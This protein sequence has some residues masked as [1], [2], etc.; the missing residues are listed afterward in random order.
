M[1][2]LLLL[3]L[4]NLY[5]VVALVPRVSAQNPP[6]Y[7]VTGA[8]TRALYAPQPEYSPTWPEGTGI[9]GLHV[10]TSTGSVRSAEMIQSTGHKVLDDSAIRAFSEW[11]FGRPVAPAIKF[12]I[13]F[14]HRNGVVIGH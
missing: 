9:V 13:S 6:G 7:P 14:S 12:P 1:I 8:K 2:R 11:R 4:M 10:D 3:L 5:T